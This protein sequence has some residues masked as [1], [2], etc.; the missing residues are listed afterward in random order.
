MLINLVA[1]LVLLAVLVDGVERLAPPAFEDILRA[2][3]V[4]VA[5]VVEQLAN[6]R[7]VIPVS[8]A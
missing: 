2:T 6:E 8:P 5:A 3:R 1:D 4:A 7:L